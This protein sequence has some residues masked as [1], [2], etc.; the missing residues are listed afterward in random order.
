MRLS[1]LLASQAGNGRS[2]G[3]G[4]FWRRAV[5]AE[6]DA[7]AVC[8][9]L[10]TGG[11][12][13]GAE[14]TDRQHTAPG[15][16]HILHG[17]KR[18]SSAGGVGCGIFAGDSRIPGGGPPRRPGRAAGGAALHRRPFRRADSPVG[19]RERTAGPCRRTAG[20]GDGAGE[21]GRRSAGKRQAAADAG[22]AA[23]PGGP[24]GASASGGPGAA[25]PV[26]PIP[27]GGHLHR[28]AAGGSDRLGG[29]L[30]DPSSGCDGGAVPH[31]TWNGIC[32]PLGRRCEKGRRP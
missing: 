29:N 10:R 4:G 26:D 15:Q 7:A 24:A 20:A 22:A 13:P 17:C 2:D 1:G 25:A 3:P 31:D 18:K 23:V 27:C 9:V 8:P 28:A 19:Q 5:S 16:R 32:G 12:R 14:P 11:S 21:P 30:R 6:V